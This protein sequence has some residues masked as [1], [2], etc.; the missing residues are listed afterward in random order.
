MLGRR[1]AGAAEH[2]PS[3]CKAL[4]SNPS[5]TQKKKK[6]DLLKTP[7]GCKASS[8]SEER[9]CEAL[10]DSLNSHLFFLIL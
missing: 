4:S 8:C 10:L 6:S 1:C 9:A 3:N 5:T 7:L 2:L